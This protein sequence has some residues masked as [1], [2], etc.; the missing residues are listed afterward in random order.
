MK[1]EKRHLNNFQLRTNKTIAIALREVE[2]NNSNN[3]IYSI[4]RINRNEKIEVKEKFRLK[5]GKPQ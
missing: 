5:K 1:L 4:H 3:S 2:M